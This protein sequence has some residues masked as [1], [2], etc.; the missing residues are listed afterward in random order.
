M[1]TP[2]PK[3]K[4]SRILNINKRTYKKEN[5]HR[6]IDRIKQYATKI[7]DSLTTEIIVFP[8]DI[9]KNIYRSYY[10]DYTS[11]EF[12]GYLKIENKSFS[13]VKLTNTNL[14]SNTEIFN[15]NIKKKY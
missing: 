12:G 11:I 7:N 10:D 8:K 5:L 1:S 6:I 3:S 14:N 9:I 2:P 15:S 4:K 13:L